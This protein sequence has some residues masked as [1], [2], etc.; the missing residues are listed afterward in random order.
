MPNRIANGFKIYLE[1]DLEPQFMD[2]E[3]IIF[4]VPGSDGKIY[5]VSIY[6][7]GCLCDCDDYHGRHKKEPGSYICKHLWAVFF[8]L[9]EINGLADILKKKA[10]ELRHPIE[11]HL[12]LLDSAD[13]VVFNALKEMEEGGSQ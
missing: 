4:N 7:N 1:N 6:D 5:Q 9:A 10:N 3:L 13:N 2:D 11:E 12:K 8:K